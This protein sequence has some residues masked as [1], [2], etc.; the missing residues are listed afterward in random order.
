MTAFAIC[1]LLFVANLLVYKNAAILLPLTGA[2][3]FFTGMRLWLVRRRER[4]TTRPV[5]HGP[6]HGPQRKAGAKQTANLSDLRAQ[7]GGSAKRGAKS[8]F[9]I[10]RQEKKRDLFEEDSVSAE[11]E[12]LQVRK[13]GKVLYASF[14]CTKEGRERAL[15]AFNRENADSS[16][17]K[18]ERPL[19]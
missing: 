12:E 16:E 8:G 17:D 5:Y 13:Q 11:F 3:C 9:N 19:Q 1:L 15:E 6:G 4:K 2:M 10:V 7:K 14:P 18:E